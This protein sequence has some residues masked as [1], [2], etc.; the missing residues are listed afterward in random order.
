MLNKCKR[1]SFVKPY[2]FLILLSA[3]TVRF[4]KGESA[5]INALAMI[6]IPVAIYRF[7]LEELGFRNFRKGLIYGFLASVLIF[8]IY[9]LF[10]FKIKGFMNVNEGILRISLFYLIYTAIPEEIFFRGFMYA[11]VENE[12]LFWKISK[13]NL[14]TSF[15]FALAHVLVYYNPAMFKTFFPALV[16]GFLYERS[17]SIIAPVIFH[18]LSDVIYTIFPV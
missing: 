13:A 11:S 15:L 16:F 6:G 8:P 12:P 18:W 5:A 2:F 9:A 10:S 3:L 7:S 17:G 1:C 4:V 14:V